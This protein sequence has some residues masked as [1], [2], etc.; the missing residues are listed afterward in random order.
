MLNPSDLDAFV[1]LVH[2]AEGIR[3]P[4]P[5]SHP[6]AVLRSAVQADH[7]LSRNEYARLQRA[8]R[9]ACVAENLSESPHRILDAIVRSLTTEDRR[10]LPLTQVEPWLR[11]IQWA[12]PRAE[13]SPY[14][15]PR[16]R[17]LD[18]QFHV[19]TACG[20]L[21]ARG[22]AVPIGA[23]GPNLDSNTRREIAEQVDSLVRC[24]G[25]IAAIER[26]CGFVSAAGR[27]HDGM[28]LLGNVTGGY[29]NAPPPA[30]PVGWLLSIALRHIH[31][32]PSDGDPDESW[33]S[34]IELAIDFAASMD[35][36]R[37]N[38]FDGLF[39]DASDFLPALEESMKWRELFTV[40]QVPPIVLPT[41]RAA[42]S[43]VS[44]PDGMSELRYE[45]D[46]LF[47]ELDGLI[48][49]L[50][51]DRLTAIPERTARSS[52]PLLCRNA[53]APRGAVNERYL[54]P[55]GPHPRDHDRYV[56]FHGDG[57]LKFM[58]PASMTSAAACEAIFRLIWTKAGPKKA[59][60]L[61]GDTLEKAVAIA[62]RRSHSHVWEKASYRAQRTNLEIDVAVRD[63]QEIVL[64]ETKA[65]A[66]TA[67]ART[68]D[69]VAFIN[70]YSKSFLALLRQL[71]R[72]D[73]NIRSGLTPLTTAN[74]DTS[75]LRVRKVAVSA[76]SFG[77]VSDHVL[78]NALIRSIAQA[79]LI[80]VDGTP[81]HNQILGAFNNVVKQSM[82]DIDQIVRSSN[83]QVDRITYMMDVLWLDL[84][85]LLYALHRGH[86]AIHGV[87]P[88]NHL[89][90]C[91]RDFWTE[92]AFADRMGLTERNWRT[93]DR[94]RRRR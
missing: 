68:G 83:D 4:R 87:S 89:T 39:P 64:F 31:V 18:R 94:D 61:V 22:Y 42:F 37:Y 27:V 69:M 56:F 55:F 17:G 15:S 90:F 82:R 14:D 74:D 11:A 80:S 93:F 91:T 8:L 77:S 24:I 73:R 26:L 79:Q 88:L 7:L 43:R 70:D 38:Q 52:F 41:L 33:K 62:C 32:R 65:K 60:C 20:R 36:Q 58:L 71:A 48:S 78:T 54:D 25:G 81:G 53:T 67:Q 76:L 40:P 75:T 5:D 84:G 2:R 21:H 45:V 35:C 46:Q 34:A 30:I 59:D 13:P 1:A 50:P 66:L 51:V 29:N 19:G 23:L 16:L 44:W 3:T 28:W 6:D 49:E 12:I 63:G 86:S 72:H 92:A 85:Q 47:S 9:I 57:N 10:Y